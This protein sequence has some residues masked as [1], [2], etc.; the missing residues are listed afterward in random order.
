MRMTTI[1][2]HTSTTFQKLQQLMQRDQRGEGISH[3]GLQSKS[4]DD[5]TQQLWRKSSGWPDKNGDGRTD[6]TYEFRVP[7]AGA[8][9]R[10]SGKVGFTPVG[11]NQRKQTALSLQAIEDVANVQFTQG[12][13]SP[14]SEGHITI[15]NYGQRTDGTGRP[16]T[17]H[18]H[19]PGPA[20]KNG[21]DVWFVNTKQQSAVADAALGSSGRNTITHELG[22]AMGLAHPGT[23]T[24]TGLKPGQVNSLEDSHSHTVMSYRGEQNTYMNHQGFKAS[25]P[26]LDDI[27]AYQKKYGANRETRNDDT[28]YGFNSNTDRDFLSVQA[29]GDK[30]VASIWDGGG[31]DTLDFSRYPQDQQISLKEGTFSDVGNLKGNISIAHGT[32]IE[33]AIGGAGNDALVGN[34]ADNTLKGGDGNDRLYGGQGADTLWGGAG[35]DVFVYGNASEST[36]GSRDRIMD[37]VS[38]EDSVDVSGLRAAMGKDALTF[39]NEFSGAAGEARLDYDPVLNMSSLQIAGKHSEAAFV[40]EVEGKLQRGDIV[41]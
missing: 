41:G 27:S 40:L 2:P 15:G 10:Q 11:E 29:P 12:P 19:Y 6:V 35:K 14:S 28:T 38:G 18:A 31:V 20:D 7:P 39:V 37:F 23:Y 22:H 3:K 24:G 13:R 26:Q 5:A 32:T 8:D 17:H 25:A 36:Q 9:T 30:I 34:E 16:N 33:N 21:G 4:S 1:S